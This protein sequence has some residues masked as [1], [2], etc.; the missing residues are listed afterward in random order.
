[1]GGAFFGLLAKVGAALMARKTGVACPHYV[2]TE[3]SRG[4]KRPKLPP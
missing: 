4:S 2:R 3:V 1:M